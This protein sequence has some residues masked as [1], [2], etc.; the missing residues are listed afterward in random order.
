M[1]TLN[2]SMDEFI[3]FMQK[4][5][6][7]DEFFKVTEDSI[8]LTMKDIQKQTLSQLDDEIH[9]NNLITWEHD[10]DGDRMNTDNLMEWLSL[11]YTVEKK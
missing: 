5:T 10:S 2:E 7:P 3:G 11:Y 4:Y 1:K 6:D 8:T 9:S